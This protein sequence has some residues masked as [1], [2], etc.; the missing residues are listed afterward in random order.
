MIV[1]TPLVDFI[2]SMLDS[3]TD[4]SDPE[5]VQMKENATSLLAILSSFDDEQ[6]CSKLCSDHATLLEIL[7]QL[8]TSYTQS[9]SVHENIVFTLAN[10]CAEPN[11]LL[12]NKV[13]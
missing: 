12:T 10:I 3:Y 4:C 2:G 7:A 11:Q 8:L 1:N 9:E 13:V 6:I 5:A